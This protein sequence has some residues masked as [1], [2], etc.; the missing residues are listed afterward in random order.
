MLAG[1]NNLSV[2]LNTLATIISKQGHPALPRWTDMS[3]QESVLG[4]K[5]WRDPHTGLA[6]F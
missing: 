5:K 1:I 2:V 6:T 4:T 3:Q